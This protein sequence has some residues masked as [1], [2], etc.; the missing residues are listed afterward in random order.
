[1]ENTKG[2]NV[3]FVNFDCQEKNLQNKVHVKEKK[4]FAQ[5]IASWNM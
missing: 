5:Q 1:M 2:K 4:L 3:T